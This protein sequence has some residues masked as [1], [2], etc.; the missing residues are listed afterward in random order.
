[1]KYLIL[2]AFVMAGA[3]AAD[4]RS[5]L[6]FFVGAPDNEIPLLRREARLDM[7]DYFNNGLANTVVNEFGG[8]S[9]VTEADERRLVAQLSDESSL[10][11]D[12]LTAGSDTVIAVI[13]TVLLPMADSRITFYDADWQP[14]RRQPNMPGMREFAGSNAAVR[15]LAAAVPMF[16]VRATYRPADDVFVFTNTTAPYFAEN[17]RPDVLLALP[18]TIELRY[19]KGKWKKI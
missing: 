7:A 2:L 14:L 5:A 8:S 19:N 11:L 4:A 17:E 6:D 13:T 12:V 10:E 3:L 15:A 1:M 18:A 16:F 9:R